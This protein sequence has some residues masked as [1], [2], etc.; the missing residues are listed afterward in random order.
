MTTSTL[1]A[2]RSGDEAP[3]HELT[4]PHLHELHVHCYRMLGSADDADDLLQETLVAAWRGL[5]DFAGRSSLRS[6]LYRIATNRCLNA[7]RAD[8][9]RPPSPVPP[10]DPPPPTRRSDTTWLQPYP[11]DPSVT[12]ERREVIELAFV[13]ALQT[14]PPRQTAAL[15]LVD[16]LGFSPAEA[17]GMLDARPAAV[18]GLLQ[19]ARAGTAGAAAT[20]RP[21]AAQEGRLARRLADA[22]TANDVDA[23]VALLTDDAWLAMPPAPHVYVGREDIAAFLRASAAGRG[24]RYVLVPVRA[25]GQPAFGC[26]LA[27]GAAVRGTGILVVT[28]GTGGITGLTRF[29]DP[30]LHPRFGLPGT[31]PDDVT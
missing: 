4:A 8:K 21:D 16:V 25:N 5:G 6:W 7:I 18:K 2:A 27:D 17:A 1:E 12:A 31:L 15:L 28:V 30:S 20:T 3:F 26:Y 9:R 10:F 29:L 13:A 23:V 22:F 24:G 14:L 11:D 19:R